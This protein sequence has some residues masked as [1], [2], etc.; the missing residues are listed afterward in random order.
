M[1]LQSPKDENIVLNV[2]NVSP[3]SRRSFLNSLNG[4]SPFADGVDEP[5]RPDEVLD[6]AGGFIAECR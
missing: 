4:N 6:G 1:E 2:R 3:S 5:K